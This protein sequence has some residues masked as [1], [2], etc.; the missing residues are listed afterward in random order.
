M[1]CDWAGAAI[2]AVIWIAAILLGDILSRWVGDDTA[3][4][5]LLT[6]G[7]FGVA[8]GQAVRARCI[9]HHLSP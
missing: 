7:V 8:A 9:T 3:G 2:V 5:L 4:F 1:K 6:I